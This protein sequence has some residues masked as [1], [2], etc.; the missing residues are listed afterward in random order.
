MADN[1]VGDLIKRYRYEHTQ[2]EFVEKSHLDLDLL[3]VHEEKDMKEVFASRGNAVMYVRYHGYA[4][5]NSVI[6]NLVK[7]INN[8]SD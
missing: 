6:E 2:D 8:I 7:K 4:D 5:V 1:L 3:I